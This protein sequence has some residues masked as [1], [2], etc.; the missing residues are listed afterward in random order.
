[1]VYLERRKRKD[2][3]RQDIQDIAHLDFQKKKVNCEKQIESAR[4]HCKKHAKALLDL[5]KKRAERAPVEDDDT[6]FC[7]STIASPVATSTKQSK[8]LSAKKVA[9]K[10][11]RKCLQNMRRPLKPTRLPNI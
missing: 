5:K 10:K 11:K 1:M 4:K 7:S 8:T 9:P 2:Q 3:F 6:S